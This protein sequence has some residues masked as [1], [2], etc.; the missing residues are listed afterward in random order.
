M[1]FNWSWYLVGAA[2]AA[3]AASPAWED[4]A[5]AGDMLTFDL[6]RWPW[7]N[8]ARSVLILLKMKLTMS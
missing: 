1:P 3:A 4:T 6:E 8:A 5:T 7:K 2:A